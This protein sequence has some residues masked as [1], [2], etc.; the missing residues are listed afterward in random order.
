MGMLL[1]FN[2]QTIS[3]NSGLVKVPEG[4]R[5]GWVDT[6]NSM[7]LQLRTEKFMWRPSLVVVTPKFLSLCGASASKSVWPAELGYVTPYAGRAEIV[8]GLERYPAGMMLFIGRVLLMDRT[9]TH[10]QEGG[11][12]GSSSE[13]QRRRRL[14]CLK[15]LLYHGV[16]RRTLETQIFIGRV[17]MGKLG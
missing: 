14:R 4:W 7:P 13:I 10:T 1:A 16:E 15:T 5:T 8:H 6:P 12:V 3:S 11:I 9:G 17:P 2:A